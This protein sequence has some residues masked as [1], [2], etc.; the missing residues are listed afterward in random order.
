MHVVPRAVAA[1]LT[2]LLH[3]LILFAL[4]RV[5]SSV[6]KPPPPPA[7]QEMTVDKLYETGEWRE[8]EQTFAEEIECRERLDPTDSSGSTLTIALRNR[9]ICLMNLGRLD[10]AG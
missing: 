5:T 2:V 4:L 3:L 9:A 7:W 1:T 8:A 10:E 6:V